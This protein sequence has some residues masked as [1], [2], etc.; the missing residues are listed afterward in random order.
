M[1]KLS[2]KLWAQNN[3]VLHSSALTKLEIKHSAELLGGALPIWTAPI[4]KRTPQWIHCQKTDRFGK[5][6]YMQCR[7]QWFPG[8]QGHMDASS[9]SNQSKTWNRHIHHMSLL[10]N[11]PRTAPSSQLL[12]TSS[13]ANSCIEVMEKREPETLLLFYI[14]VAHYKGLFCYYQ[15]DLMFVIFQCIPH[16]VI[17]LHKGVIVSN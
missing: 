10:S 15:V 12:T 17:T 16:S 9:F 7:W 5:G 1:G 13:A 14:H 4:S 2:L 6:D 8:L 11:A 3:W